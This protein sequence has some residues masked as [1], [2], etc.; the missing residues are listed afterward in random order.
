MVTVGISNITKFALIKK[1][2]KQNVYTVLVEPSKADYCH[3]TA[4][5]LSA[6][7]NPRMF[8]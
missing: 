8:S 1:T 4:P 6:A 2:K 5:L 7:I 3:I